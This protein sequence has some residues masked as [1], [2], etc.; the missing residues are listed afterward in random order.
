MSII[1]NGHYQTKS[2]PI[3]AG[4]PDGYVVP[5]KC[6]CVVHV[7]RWQLRHV[8]VYRN[9]GLTVAI[10]ITGKSRTRP[11]RG[12]YCIAKNVGSS[13]VVP[14][15]PNTKLPFALLIMRLSIAAFFGAWTSLKFLRP[16]WFE[17]VFQNAYG[18]EFISQEMAW[19]VGLTQ[20]AI[21][22]AFTVGFRRTYSYALLGLM[23]AAGV[24]G[25]I[26]SLINYTQYPNNLMWA[27]I[28]ALG[29]AIALFLLRDYDKY[30]I[31]GWRRSRDQDANHRGRDAQ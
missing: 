30:S 12:V 16:E 27:A 5:V 24:I 8:A 11:K 22:V 28:P 21:V 17:N 23:Q 3:R 13:K 19:V 1:N 29:S 25:S 9:A 6:T 7:A 31:D 2:R 26:P 18:L 4:T 10:Y 15:M 14:E 20:V